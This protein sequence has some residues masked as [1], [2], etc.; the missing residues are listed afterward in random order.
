ARS[1]K[2]AREGSLFHDNVPVKVYDALIEA[3][4][5]HLPTN[6][7]YLA[8]RRKALKIDNVHMY[9]TYAP[10][11]A[12]IEKHHTWDQ[13]ARAVT[14]ALSPLGDEY[15]RALHDGLTKRRWSDRYPN[16]GKS[17]GAFS[18]GGFDGPPY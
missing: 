7:R 13:A 1:Y 17:S 2:S 11:V 15:C 12:G 16:V 5:K 8:L 18:S 6:H 9:D 10:M 3:V 14:D 4:H